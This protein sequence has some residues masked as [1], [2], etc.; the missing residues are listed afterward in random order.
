MCVTQ[1]NVSHLVSTANRFIWC[2]TDENS[3]ARHTQKTSVLYSFIAIL[4]QID[5]AFPTTYFFFVNVF[6]LKRKQRERGRS[7]TQGSQFYIRYHS[8][9]D[10]KEIKTRINL[11]NCFQLFVFLSIYSHSSWIQERG[12]V[13]SNIYEMNFSHCVS[14]SKVFR[15][16]YKQT[17]TYTQIRKIHLTFNDHEICSG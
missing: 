17:H 3:T 10:W 7:R 14:S 8:I 11:I 6:I 1:I 2:T 9:F 4:T 15:V 16:G 5:K 12:K 13:L